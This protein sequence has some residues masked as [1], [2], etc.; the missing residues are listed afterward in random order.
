MPTALQALADLAALRDHL[1]G[2]AAALALGDARAA[3]LA[4]ACDR[5][6]NDEACA[7]TLC[8]AFGVQ[9][10]AGHCDP[11]KDLRRERW[12]DMLRAAAD[13][14]PGDS[15]SERARELHR[16]LSRYRD[17]PRWRQDRIAARCPYE[18]GTIAALL[19]EILRVNPAVLSVERLRKVVADLGAEGPL[20]T[21]SDLGETGN[22]KRTKGATHGI[23]IR[24]GVS[25][26]PGAGSRSAAARGAGAAAAVAPDYR[27]S[28]PRRRRL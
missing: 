14:L 12:N 28:A 9:R 6:L 16:R 24:T 11:R 23:E 21:T 22:A 5:W 27:P 20:S 2:A 1:R 3:G 8:E 19:F 18:P 26:R 25:G 10:E 4:G 13:R 15:L 17:S 7:V